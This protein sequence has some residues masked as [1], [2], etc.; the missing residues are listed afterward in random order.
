MTR[1]G[2]H[3]LTDP[4]H[5][6]RIVDAARIAVGDRVLEI[7]PGRGHLTQHLIDAGANVT[8]IEIDEHL[9]DKLPGRVEDPDDRLT[10]IRGDALEQPW[11]TFDKLVSNLPYQASSPILFQ[12]IEHDYEVA[13]LTV[14]KEFAD[15]LTAP[16]GTKHASRLTVKVALEADAEQLF[17]IPPGAFTPP[18]EVD[19]AVVRLV[20]KPRDPVQDEALLARLID[21]AFQHRRKMLRSSLRGIPHARRVLED[22]G[23]GTQR[24]A[25]LTLPQWI[26][27]AD[28]VHAAQ[29]DDHA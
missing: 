9:S 14:Q 25:K 7:G 23:L 5:L 17:T 6:S 10:L 27:L 22:H 13:V 28:A 26:E 11:P 16:L 2:Q 8:A 4:N 3:F 24:P 15:R 20:P 21:T 19:S 12:L 18:P 29:E 1:L